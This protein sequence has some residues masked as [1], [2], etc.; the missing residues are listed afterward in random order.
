MSDIPKEIQ[1]LIDGIVLEEDQEEDPDWL[2][3][4]MPLLLAKLGKGIKDA[5]WKLWVKAWQDAI[6]G[7]FDM[8]TVGDTVGTVAPALVGS[9][10]AI[11]Y[12]APRCFMWVN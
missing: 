11:K 10:A 9:D 1:D 12:L 3:A 7:A 2:K 8:G 5:N 6:Q 4:L